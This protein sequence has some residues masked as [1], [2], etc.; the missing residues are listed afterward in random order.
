MDFH[1]NL[2]E[3]RLHGL[4]GLS[5]SLGLRPEAEAAS[6]LAHHTPLVSPLF[7]DLGGT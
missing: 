5:G 7:V 3:G 2:R 1:A 6:S 4:R